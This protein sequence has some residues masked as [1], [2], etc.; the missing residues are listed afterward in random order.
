MPPPPPWPLALS[1]LVTALLVWPLLIASTCAIAVVLAFVLAGHALAIHA[2]AL[3]FALGGAGQF[4]ALG[5]YRYRRPP[6]E[7]ARSAV[8]AFLMLGTATNLPLGVAAFS[9][10]GIHDL[11]VVACL[12]LAGLGQLVA[13]VALARALRDD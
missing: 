11:W 10:S 12:A 4:V 1:R 13:A 5:R 7:A 6:G 3:A 2:T 9:P 8:S